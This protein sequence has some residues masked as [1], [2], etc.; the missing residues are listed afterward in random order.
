[1]P[2]KTAELHIPVKF[3]PKMHPE[4]GP[5]PLFDAHRYHVFYGGRGGGKS[6]SIAQCL[7]ARAT[8]KRYRVLCAREFQTSLKD[9]VWELLCQKIEVMGLQDFFKMEQQAI[10]GQNG[11][12]FRFQGIRSNIASIKS[13]EGYDC[14]WCEEAANISDHSWDVLLP[15][16]MRKKDAEVFISFNP[17]YERDATYQRWVVKPPVGS[18]VVKV[19]WYDNPFIEPTFIDQIEEMKLK[20]PDK[21]AWIYGGECRKYL[22]GAVY[23][24]EIRDAEAH[25]Q[26]TKVIYDANGSGVQAVFDIGIADATGIWLVQRSG[27]EI[28]LLAYV[29][30]TGHAVNWY[31]EKINDKRNFPFQ[32]EKYWLPHDARARQYGTGLSVE[33]QLKIKGHNVGIVPSLSIADGINACRNMWPHMWFD[34]KNCREGIEALRNY[35]YSNKADVRD[36]DR[37]VLK[38]VPEH[39]WASHCADALRYA[40]IVMRPP[41]PKPDMGD[42]GGANPWDKW[43]LGASNTGWMRG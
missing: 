8:Q 12:I 39:N 18:C 32:I 7:I 24:N 20:E 38:N 34:E 43:R 29:E 22:D 28:H 21:Y 13:F 11:S 3:V 35:I 40:A 9:S 31:I 17:E 14:V 6:H 42:F 36:P 10:M 33:E 4:T 2:K 5:S 19:N 26:F 1:M 37:G 27:Q 15:T 25:D 41:R 23:K 16:I 30:D